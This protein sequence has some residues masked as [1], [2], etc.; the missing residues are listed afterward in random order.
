M[1][2]FRGTQS[3][4]GRSNKTERKYM[5]DDLVQRVNELIDEEIYESLTEEEARELIALQES[6]ADPEEV[7]KWIEAHVP[8]YDNII[9][10]NVIIAVGEQ[11]ERSENR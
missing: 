8:D 1:S 2:G 6:G 4:N 3:A 5:N 10:D 9:E 7:E 11:M